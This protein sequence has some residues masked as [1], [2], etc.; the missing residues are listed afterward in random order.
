[1]GRYKNYT[2]PDDFDDAVDAYIKQ[3]TDNGLPISWTGLALH[4][5]FA[6]RQCID[7]YA[8]YDGFS[9]SV[10]RAKTL[11]E[12]FYEEKLM[13]GGGAG[14]IFALKNFKWKDKFDEDMVR[15]IPP[16]IINTY[17]PDESN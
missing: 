11:I 6:S 2:N 17:N 12:Q 3:R 15:E 14:A 7:R 4:L 8:D 13:D 10:K 1:M 16:I 9:D 5:G